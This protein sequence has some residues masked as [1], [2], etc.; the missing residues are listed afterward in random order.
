M[1]K[2]T[3]MSFVMALLMIVSAI[4]VVGTANANE[5]NVIQTLDG[6]CQ[7][8]NLDVV[9]TVWNGSA[10]VDEYYAEVGETV[11]FKINVTYQQTAPCGYLA[12]NF[13]VID[14]LDPTGGVTYTID[15]SSMNYAPIEES[16]PIQ[17]NISEDY[18]IELN[19]GE[20]FEIT[21]NV[22]I[23]TGYGELVNAVEV[24]G[25]ETCCHIDLYGTDTAT[26]IVEEEPCETRIEL[27]KTVWNGTAYAEYVDGLTIGDIVKFKIVITYIDE[28]ETGYEILNM[29][30]DDELP[31]CLE[32]EETLEITTTGEIDETTP[33]V[34]SDGKVV[35]WEW[36]FDNHV[37]LHDGDTVTII[38]TAEF[39]EYC[40]LVGENWA[41]VEAWGCS[42]PTFEDEDNALV[43][44]TS[45]ETTF[46]KTVW[47]G[48][49]WVEE[50]ET[51]EG[52]TL[53]FKL[54]LHYYGE[55][56]LR[57][58]HFYDELPCIL[59][60]AD[61]LYSNIEDIEDY[62]NVSEDK[63][64]IWWNLTGVI[65]EDGDYIIIEF[66]ALV[67][68]QTGNDCPLCECQLDVV[69]YAEV[70]GKIGC[71]A[72]PNF[73][74][75]DEVL[76]HSEG[77][78]PPSAPGVTGDT[79]AEAGEE[80]EIKVKTTDSDGDKV[81]Y[82]IDWGD[83][84]EGMVWV[85]P[86]NSSDE[87]ALTHTY[88]AAGVYEVYA[89]A[90]DVHGAESA[91]SYYPFKITI[92]EE[93]IKLDITL[94]ASVKGL[95]SA[96]VK[97]NGGDDL[98]GIDW[99]ITAAGGLF[100]GV[101]VSADGTIDLN[102]SDSTDLNGSDSAEVDTGDGSIGFGFGK[103]TGSV[104]V[105]IGDYEKEVEFSGFLLGKTIYALKIA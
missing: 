60:Y 96:T 20:S 15:Y 91:W 95:I 40:D 55:E 65:I 44:C 8:E 19:E 28:C 1:N 43:D 14:N 84:S 82:M 25:W 87:V 16:V 30:V 54:E 92:T 46:E 59:E 13:T 21:F 76:I 90:K 101:D 32:Y 9:K 85:G 34:S 68:G 27:E 23:T 77:N 94:P 104:K 80:I 66:D 103:V 38:F 6:D 99:E 56:E 61:N 33:E 12:K 31:C 79:T 4:S 93:A 37:V 74:I 24:Y 36:I 86:S 88:T 69:N 70:W 11:T 17:W 72:E 39:V 100:G 73:F 67:T 63:K 89:K 53:R 58:I 62:V 50:I 42:G 41:Y 81:Y 64:H 5:C 105:S 83:E 2:R 7:A 57:D 102:S 29:V 18:G 47:N 49:A 51:A 52:N 75:C 35:T 48:S 3:K 78:C 98:A 26:V 71:T 97:N 22:T 45:E 10:W